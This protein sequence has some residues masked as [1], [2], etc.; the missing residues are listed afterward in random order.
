VDPRQVN[1]RAFENL[2]RAGAFD[3]LEP[4]R[5]K[6]LASAEMLLSVSQNA[7]SERDSAQASLFGGGGESGGARA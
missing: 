2:A 5:A 1:K 4:D 7:Q 6:A 3:T